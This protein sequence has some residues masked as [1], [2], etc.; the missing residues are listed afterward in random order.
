M[1][2]LSSI[3]GII[4]TGAAIAVLVSLPTETPLP[5]IASTLIEEVDSSPPHS[6]Q[7][8][9]EETADR[10]L[11]VPDLRDDVTDVLAESGY[12]QFVGISKLSE[13]LP[14]DVVQVLINEESVLVIP[15][16]DGG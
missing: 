11:S 4:A 14:D 13:T 12:T 3:G 16:E 1:R 15:S 2:W 5:E 6:S 10:D 9:I 7:I 8:T